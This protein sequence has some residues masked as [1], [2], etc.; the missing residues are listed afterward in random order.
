[1]VRCH[2]MRTTLR[3][4]SFSFYVFGSQSSCLV[5]FHHI[6]GHQGNAIDVNDLSD[7]IYY[8]T[9]AYERAKSKFT[10]A[11][12]HENRYI[13]RPFLL[14]YRLCAIDHRRTDSTVISI[15]SIISSTLSNIIHTDCIEQYWT[16]KGVYLPSTHIAFNRRP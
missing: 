11:L 2:H 4:C 3:H 6:C 12:A 16:C 7:E 1:M 8:N 14:P 9:L 5:F 10:K 15:D 13:N